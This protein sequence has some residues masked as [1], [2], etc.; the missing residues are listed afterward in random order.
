M[1]DQ[2][3][4]NL[5]QKARDEKDENVKVIITLKDESAPIYRGTID[6]EKCND[7][8]IAL[9]KVDSGYSSPEDGPTYRFPRA[10]IRHVTYAGE[11][12][13]EPLF[14]FI[15]EGN[16]S[17]TGVRITREEFFGLNERGRSYRAGGSWPE[18][19]THNDDNAYVYLKSANLEGE[20]VSQDIVIDLDDV[21][22]CGD[23][24]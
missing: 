10:C 20:I 15:I 3:L 1:A 8:Q 7:K 6:I 24:W 17:L 13:G 2:L 22:C 5:I 23:R 21:N 12:K 19:F 4:V 14:W 18:G 9:R 16:H 11:L